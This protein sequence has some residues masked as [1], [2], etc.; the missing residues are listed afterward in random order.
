MGSRFP[1]KYWVRFGCELELLEVSRVP[2]EFTASSWYWVYNLGV[3][4]EL[5]GGR[6]MGLQLRC[7]LQ[8][9]ENLKGCPLVSGCCCHKPGDLIGLLP[10]NPP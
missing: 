8:L 5:L 4:E 3:N 6:A 7:N 2:H 10:L 1:L 9:L